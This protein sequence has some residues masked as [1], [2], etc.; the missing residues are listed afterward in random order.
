MAE[1]NSWLAGRSKAAVPSAAESGLLDAEA[2]MS[3]KMPSTTI[4]LEALIAHTA[5]QQPASAYGH[6]MEPTAA[7][8]DWRKLASM[9]PRGA[10]S[11]ATRRQLW[12]DASRGSRRP[13]S[14]PLLDVVELV[15]AALGRRLS[16]TDI[17]CHRAFQRLRRRATAELSDDAALSARDRLG[18]DELTLFLDQLA[19]YYEL[20]AALGRKDGAPPFEQVTL[21]SESS[22]TC[23][24]EPNLSAWM[25]SL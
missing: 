24:P 9:L 14:L 19:A 12:Q 21:R 20:Y 6:V 4:P 25:L 8:V 10:I 11:E 3:R 18:R 23:P 7:R 15:T 13:D 16:S 22:T 5:R 1:L 17:T 2:R